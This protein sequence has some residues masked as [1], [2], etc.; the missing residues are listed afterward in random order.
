MLEGKRFQNNENGDIVEVI[1]DTGM[2]YNL[3]NGS[4]IKRDIFFQKYSEMVDP[5]SFF[6]KQTVAGLSNLAEQ[7]KNLD[8]RNA[9]DGDMPPT[10]RHISESTGNYSPPTP[11]Q[12]RQEMIRRYNE[13]QAKKDLSQY[14][15]FD[16]EDEAASDFERRQKEIQQNQI[17]QRNKSLRQQ[18]LEE[19]ERFL[20][21]E[22]NIQ[23]VEYTEPTPQEFTQ[24]AY[25]SKD[26]EA[27]RFFKSF[28]RVYPVK[29]SIDFDEKIAEPNFLKMMV[30]NM[31]ADIIQYYTKE[32]MNRIHNDPGYLE[33]KIYEKLRSIVF[34]EE[35]KKPKRTIKPKVVKEEVKV[36][37]KKQPK[38]R[39][40]PSVPPKDRE[41]LQEGV[42]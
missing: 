21:G 18:K 13:N 27:Y 20:R 31:E 41:R 6:Q 8:S 1:A 28:K 7:F 26:E 10:V 38:K 42:E 39:V 11:E 35:Q 9:V 33:T 23:N 36:P 14:K 30:T 17:Q 12:D 29:L 4:N 24:P 40:I 22:Q 16:N 25:V 37:T 5:T 19:E 3:S 34:E 2:F 15:V 32:I